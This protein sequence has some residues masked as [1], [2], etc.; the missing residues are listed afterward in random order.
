MIQNLVL[1]KLFIDVSAFLK[2]FSTAFKFGRTLQ[3]AVFEKVY[4]FWQGGSNRKLVKLRAFTIVLFHCFIPLL[5]SIVLSHYFIPFFYSVIYS[6]LFHFLFHFFIPLFY[7]VVLFH[8][9]I[10]FFYSVIVSH[11]KKHQWTMTSKLL[12]DSFVFFGF[13]S[14]PKGIWETFLNY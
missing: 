10:P 8:S 4:N 7:S 14:W 1:M 2:I 9:F 11:W 5:Y 12:F 13:F 3:T 6:I